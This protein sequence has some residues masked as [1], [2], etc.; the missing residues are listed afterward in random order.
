MAQVRKR[1]YQ[2]DP[3]YE[4]HLVV[5]AGARGSAAAG[6]MLE[7]D[8]NS[9]EYHDIVT[10]S[11]SDYSNYALRQAALAEAVN[12]GIL[13]GPFEGGEGDF[14][15][16]LNLADLQ[17]GFERTE[18]VGMSGTITSIAYSVVTPTSDPASEVTLAVVYGDNEA[19][20]T[21]DGD[22]ASANFNGSG[23]VKASDQLTIL[24]DGIAEPFTDGAGLLTIEVSE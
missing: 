21:L 1:W 23:E 16:A 3:S 17:A 2:V 24:V 10:G 18:A 11:V 8:L 20:L 6:E 4:G 14:T 13:N 12:E 22:A 19:E 9:D 5:L 15:T 7:V